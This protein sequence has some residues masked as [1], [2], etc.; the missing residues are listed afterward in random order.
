M[1]ELARLSVTYAGG[2]GPPTMIAKIPTQIEQNRALGKSLGIYEREV[3]VY[4]EDPLRGFLPSI[5]RL[6]HYRE[7]TADDMPEGT[8]L[9]IDSGVVEGS[10]V[11]MYYDPMIAKVVTHGPD[12]AAAVEA[13]QAALDAFLVRGVRH[14]MSFLAAVMAQRRFREGRLTTNYIAEEFPDGYHGHTL[15]EALQ[16]GRHYLPFHTPAV[17]VRARRELLDDAER[18]NRMREDNFRCYRHHVRPERLILRSRVTAISHA[19]H[20]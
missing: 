17:C 7:P 20:T 5:G 6:V 19:R 13:M 4:A 8:T 15:P 3:R 16:E 11:T 18:A 12:R 1:G 14:N 2:G 10:E 9:R